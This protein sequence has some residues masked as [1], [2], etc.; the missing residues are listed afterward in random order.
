VLTKWLIRSS[1]NYNLER[2][3]GSTDSATKL[4]A[5][6]CQQRLFCRL[7]AEESRFIR[8]HI[9]QAS[10]DPTLISENEDC[11]MHTAMAASRILVLPFVLLSASLLVRAQVDTTAPPQ[12]QNPP[13][14][15]SP[16]P[17]G[18]PDSTRLEVIKA[19]RPDYPAQAAVK[20][21]QGEVWIKLLVSETGDVEST[22]IISGDPDLAK[23]TAAAMKKWKFK[24]F[25]KDGRA[26]KV[27]TKIPYDFA[28]RGYVF[29]T[30]PPNAPDTAAPQDSP[31]L[32]AP[33]AAGGSTPSHENSVPPRKLR[34]SPGVMDGNLIHRVNPVYPPEAR[35]NHIQGTVLLNA[36]IGRDGRL[37]DLKAISGPSELVEAS[38]GAVQQWRYRPYM[39]NG[40]PVDVETTI[41]IQFHM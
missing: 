10:F 7:S 19:P 33:A 20:A 28:V 23:A 2:N 15:A 37:Y 31:S 40:E 41:K 5:A 39:L 16:S 35:R 9:F 6:T 38:I 21:L 32:D 27:T 36:R 14:A 18:L 25:I 11:L 26:I 1:G 30:K 12:S 4:G 3:A 29:D 24:P 13:A 34:V 17:P 8:R 22:E